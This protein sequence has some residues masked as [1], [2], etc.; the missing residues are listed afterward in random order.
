MPL[1]MIDRALARRLERVEGSTNAAFVEARARTFPDVGADW[2]EIA[3]AYAMFDGV[4][5]PLTQTFGA[6]MSAPFEAAAFESAEDFFFSRGAAAH[7][8]IA[9]FAAAETIALLH[10]RGYTRIERS[11]V[12]LRDTSRLASPATA[13]TVRRIATDEYAAW[14]KV[15][16]EGWSSAGPE[17][18]AFV[19]QLG[20]TMAQAR[21][22]HCFVGELEGA[23]IA[24]SA[25][26]LVDGVAL[27]AGAS[28]VPAA[29][30]RGAQ[31]ALLEARLA[32]AAAHGAELAMVVT[33][34]GS[35]SQRNAERA[36]FA[37]VYGR[38]KWERRPG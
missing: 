27:L 30:G 37:P 23:P 34:P 33:E 32:F 17:V 29:R 38:T 10:A 5:S 14:A 28:T 16:A 18:S 7:H 4:G 11:T 13:V 2:T 1:P 15:S 20:R 25:L 26:Y 35:A 24:A 6:G 22:V 3:G 12:L 21:G 19:E 31:R 36:G 8:E 9:E